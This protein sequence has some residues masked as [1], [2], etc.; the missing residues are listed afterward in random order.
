MLDCCAYLLPSACACL[1]VPFG[2]S[3]MLTCAKLHALKSRIMSLAMRAADPRLTDYELLL[4]NLRDLKDG[5]DVQASIALIFHALSVV[6]QRTH[7]L[8]SCC[9]SRFDDR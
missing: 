1:R 7:V 4:E 8:S 3:Y 5:K 6:W 9:H 2:H